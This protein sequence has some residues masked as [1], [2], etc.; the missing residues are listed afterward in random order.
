MAAPT[1]S[2]PEMLGGARNWDYRYTWI[3]DA[4]FTLYALIRLGFTEETGAFIGWLEARLPAA[5]RRRARCSSCTASTAASDLPEEELP[6]LEGYLGSRPVRIGNGAAK[7]LQL[8]IYGELMDSVY[9]VQQ[10]RRSR[11]PTTS[12][13]GSPAASSG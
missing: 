13:C 7:Q 6:H 11:S 10:V 2:L 1:F 5:A 12:G 3:R 4:A 9:L 8:D